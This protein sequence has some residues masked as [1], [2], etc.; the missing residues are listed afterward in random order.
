MNKQK[1]EK[2]A[3]KIREDWKRRGQVATTEG[4]MGDIKDHIGLAEDVLELRNGRF[5]SL[6]DKKEVDYEIQPLPYTDYNG[7]TF[8][9]FYGCSYLWKGDPVKSTQR[10]IGLA[11]AM[12]SK[13]PSQII[14]PSLAL[15]SALAFLFLFA[16]K[17]FY[18]YLWHYSFILRRYIG[19][20]WNE[21]G[22]IAGIGDQMPPERMN[23]MTREIRRAMNKA[24]GGNLLTNLLPKKNLPA[25]IV[26]NIMEFVYFFIEY[27]Q[28]YRFPAQD[29]LGELNKENLRKDFKKELSRVFDILI[30]RAQSD[31]DK[32]LEETFRALKKSV[33]LL[34]LIKDFGRIIKDFL[35]ELDIDRVK[36]DEHDWYFSYLR[37]GYNYGGMDLETRRKIREKIDEEKGHISFK[38]EKKELSEEDK[39]YFQKR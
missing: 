25:Y 10:E 3:Q 35:L 8:T 22:E 29:I 17:N 39:K 28:A 18:K 27:D 5:Y 1:A 23:V 34:V 15:K 11:K 32:R 24:L 38:L 7:G 9:K 37:T 19:A 33:I 6:I 30:E 14:L 21:K 26:A 13:I 20:T 4:A 2:L 31:K 16:R 12:L 36:L